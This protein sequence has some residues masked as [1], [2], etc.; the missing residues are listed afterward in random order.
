MKNTHKKH[1]RAQ[2]LQCFSLFMLHL[3]FPGSK[4][5]STVSVRMNNPQH[6]MWW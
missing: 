1:Q 4:S 5:F 3:L 6:D 2:N